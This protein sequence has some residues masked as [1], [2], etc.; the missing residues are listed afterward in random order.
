MDKN[1]AVIGTGA[2]GSCVAADLTHAGH[3]PKLIDQW[4]EHV[5]AMRADGLHISMPD[6]ELHVAVDAH[7][8]CDV[9]TLSD[10]FDVVFVMAKA[11]DTRWM[12]EMITPYLSKDALVIGI[13]NAM[14]A[15]EISELVGPARTLGCVIELSSEITRPGHVRRNTPPSGT[16]IAIGSF[17]PSTRTR[18]EEIRPLVECIG[19]VEISDSILATKWMKLVVNSMTMGPQALLGVGTREALTIPQ[20]RGIAI[21]AG[22][23]ALAVGQARGYSVEPVFGLTRKDIEGSNRL[24]EILFDK[25]MADVGP[26]GRATVLYD[27]E[28]GRLSEVDRING[29]VVEGGIHHGIPTPVNKAVA[30]LTQRI[31]SGDLTPEKTN[32]DLL[33]D[34]IGR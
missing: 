33:L 32:L 29:L 28:N 22:S 1:I 2:N 19:K 27:H 24:L 7:H 25:L 31:H 3:K 14:T 13:Q 15:E 8:I 23:E 5:S 11:Y 10:F 9:C 20:L 12:V 4:P 16:W 26:N 18:V 17:D 30:A 21:R 6:E 34:V